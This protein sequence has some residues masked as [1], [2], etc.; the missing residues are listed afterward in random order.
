MDNISIE[1]DD[2]INDLAAQLADRSK[3]CAL[4]V[5]KCKAYEKVIARFEEKFGKLPQPE[6]NVV[7]IA[8]KE[9]T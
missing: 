3:A 5:A 8:P 6:S 2:V 7:S 4:M 9:T 1:F